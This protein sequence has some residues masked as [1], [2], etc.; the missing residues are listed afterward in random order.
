MFRHLLLY[1]RHMKEIYK[2]LLLSFVAGILIG[3]SIGIILYANIGSDTITV[4]QDGL[5]N[6]LHV[7]Y[8][9]AALIY[10]I[11]CIILALLF[12]R[13][14]FGVGSLVSAFTIGFFI[15]ISYDA[16]CDLDISLNKYLSLLVFIIGLVLYCMS[17]SM[18]MRLELGMNSIDAL[19]FALSMKIKS[20]YKIV[21]TIADLLFALVGY[22]LGGV[23]GLGTLLSILLT[24]ILIDQFNK[25]KL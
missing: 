3:V 25:I 19:L 15:D 21:R 2:K 12:A 5:H 13:K 9:Q 22:L 18:L 24:G 20:S 7:T 4:F 23:V 6:L 8:G 10:N 11:V 14:Y 16:L 1:N 17:L